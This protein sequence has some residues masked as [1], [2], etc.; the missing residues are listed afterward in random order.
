MI[1]LETIFGYALVIA[2]FI[3][4]YVGLHMVFEKDAKKTIPL[5]WEPGG[6]LFKLYKKLKKENNSDI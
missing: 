1:I 3:L 4:S 5:L 6:L 2:F